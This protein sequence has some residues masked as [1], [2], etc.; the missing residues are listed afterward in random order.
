MPNAPSDLKPSEV[1]VRAG[2]GPRASYDST[3]VAV[4]LNSF[5]ATFVHN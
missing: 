1:C 5:F 4:I 3:N 2:A